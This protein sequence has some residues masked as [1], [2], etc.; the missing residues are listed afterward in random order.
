MRLISL[1]YSIIFLLIISS[2][3]G[4]NDSS[5]SFLR[6]DCYP[7]RESP[8]SSYSKESCLA[9]HCLYDDNANSSQIQCYLSPNY[10]YILQNSI[11]KSKTE[12][13]F[14]LKRNEDV[15][16]MFPEPI[17][18]V[19]LTVQYYTNDIIRFKFSD[20]DQQRYEVK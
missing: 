7:E 1:T 4:L 12:L 18:N 9:R 17:E 11:Q 16:S 19:L 2:I 3:I 15:N 10:G 8:Y 13:E 5:S 14:K 6:I 20:A